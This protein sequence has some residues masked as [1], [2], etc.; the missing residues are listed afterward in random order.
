MNLKKKIKTLKKVLKTF[1]RLGCFI[2]C[3]CVI[4]LDKIHAPTLALNTADLLIL[5]IWYKS[6]QVHRKAL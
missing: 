3:P 5:W 1:T 4:L 6:V 2:L